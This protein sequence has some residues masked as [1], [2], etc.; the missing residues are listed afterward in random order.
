MK[1]EQIAQ[2]LGLSTLAVGALQQLEPTQVDAL[3]AAIDRALAQH[4]Q[5][6][7]QSLRN[8]IPWPFKAPLLHWLRS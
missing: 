1:H 5:A 3:S 8:A 6:L 2:Q 4:R 7:D